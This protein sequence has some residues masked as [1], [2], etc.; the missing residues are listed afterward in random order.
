MD[1]GRGRRIT[2]SQTGDRVGVHEE[3]DRA[4]EI[5]RRVLRMAFFKS[6]EFL[7]DKQLRHMYNSQVWKKS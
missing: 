3:Q 6:Q 2:G 1:V 4:C 5:N 7:L